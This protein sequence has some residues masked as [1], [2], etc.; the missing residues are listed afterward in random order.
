M[1][2][3][4]NPSFLSKTS[5]TIFPNPFFPYTETF[6]IE[7]ET[8]SYQHIL[9]RLGPFLTENRKHILQKASQRRI[10]SICVV[11]EDI[12]DLGN[13][14]AV[15]RTAE[16]L[17]IHCIHHIQTTPLSRHNKSRPSEPRCGYLASHLVL[18]KNINM[19]AKFEGPGLSNWFDQLRSKTPQEGLELK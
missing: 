5:S 4:M 10:F 6:E 8:Y 15:W 18:A 12:Y 17:G 3:S 13:A 11:L 2:S 7:G 1:K 16:A 14:H 9:N 19:S